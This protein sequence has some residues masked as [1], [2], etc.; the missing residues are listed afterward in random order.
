MANPG[1][2]RIR[3]VLLLSQIQSAVQVLQECIEGGDVPQ[4]VID[5]TSQLRVLCFKEEVGLLKPL[6]IVPAAKPTLVEK[7]GFAEQETAPAS[8]QVSK[9]LQGF[10]EESFFD[11]IKAI[12]KENAEKKAR[13]ES[14]PTLDELNSDTDFDFKKD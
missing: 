12:E 14:L 7:L 10:D 2:K 1:D 11:K 6:S 8:D 9:T 5:F 3:T 4:D 13:G